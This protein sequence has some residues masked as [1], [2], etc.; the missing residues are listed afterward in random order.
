MRK[1]TKGVEKL[2]D[3]I[4][5]GSIHFI[6]GFNEKIPK[7]IQKKMVAKSANET[8]MMGFVVDPYCYFLCYEITDLN[9]FESL[10]PDD[11]ELEKTKIFN[12]DEPKYYY[13]QGSFNARTSAF[14]GARVESYAIAKNK[15]TG[16]LAW[17]IIDYDTNTISYDSANGLTG[18]S[19]PGGV[20]TTDYAGRVIVDMKRKNNE[21]SLEFQS[22]IGNPIKRDLDYRLWIE[23][24]L[25]VAYGKKL[26]DDGDLFSL[27][28]D[29]KEMKSAWEI[30]QNDL[31]IIENT[32]EN[33]KIAS[34]PSKIVCFPYA[35]HFVSDSP[36]FRS[37]L[38]SESELISSINKINFDEVKVYSTDSFK[39]AMMRI[40]MILTI[41]IIC[42][43]ILLIL[44]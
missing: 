28:F 24:N 15:K 36:G 30:E 26:S 8:P 16:L 21:R 41:I 43:V 4:S 6:Q 38:R 25:T 5:V 2:I 32:W 40:P 42:L 19:C 27:R 29:P 20:V 34:K 13:I 18:A 39:K 35:Q 12:D 10:L 1:F 22:Y 17:V 33:G 14:F 23:G 44:K 37:D 11:F 3:P 31:D 7:N 9:Y